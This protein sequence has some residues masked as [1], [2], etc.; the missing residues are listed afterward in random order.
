VATDAI[1]VRRPDGSFVAADPVS[2]E[3]LDSIR[4]GVRVRARITQSRNLRRHRLFWAV[5]Q[6][7]WEAQGGEGGTFP[8]PEAMHDAI[9]IGLGL[10]DTYTVRGRD[11]M[12]LR[13]T[14]FDAMDEAEFSR[15]ME[16]VLSLV[17]GHLIPG[18]GRD[19]LMARVDDILGER[20]AA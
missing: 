4:P 13:S 12:R 14:S 18:T 16:S 19:D 10:Y 20:R 11:I 2:L 1:L 15:W 7:A 3:A 9:K 8:T 17:T 6:V 5:M